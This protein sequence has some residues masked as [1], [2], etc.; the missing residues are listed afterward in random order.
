M[1]LTSEHARAPRLFPR[2][3]G[4]VNAVYTTGAA[5]HDVHTSV[6]KCAIERLL[7]AR[8]LPLP[9]RSRAALDANGPTPTNRYCPTRDKH[10]ERRGPDHEFSVSNGV[11][12]HRPRV[13]SLAGVS[14][15]S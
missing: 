4:G 2:R 14:R 11:A 1:L 13:V 8:A 9:Q 7:P 15:S 10:C 12:I 6:E 3:S 5:P